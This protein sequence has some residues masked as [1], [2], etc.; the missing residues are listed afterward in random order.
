MSKPI[1]ILTVAV[2][3]G[4]VALTAA[5]PSPK[6]ATAKSKK[7][8][9]AKYIHQS[10]KGRAGTAAKKPGAPAAKSTTTASR[11]TGHTTT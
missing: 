2:F 3:V 6:A 4:A 1:S 10:S 8:A 7:T 11:R 5:T 9:H